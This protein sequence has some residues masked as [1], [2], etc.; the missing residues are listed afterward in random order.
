MDSSLYPRVCGEARYSPDMTNGE[1]GLTP[2]PAGKP[3][4]IWHTTW[5]GWVYPRV[6]GEAAIAFIV[7]VVVS[8]LPPRV[9]GSRCASH[10]LVG[11]ERSTPAPAGEPTFLRCP[12]RAIKVYPRVCGEAVRRAAMYRFYGGLPP[13]MRGSRLARADIEVAVGSTPAY[14]GK[15]C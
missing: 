6:C 5:Q 10:Q 1:M 13:R 7:A 3:E 9:R 11:E 8:G 4:L 12:I 14:A 2:A 15:P